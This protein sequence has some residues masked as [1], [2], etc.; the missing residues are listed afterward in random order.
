MQITII[1]FPGIVI[2][3]PVL[4]LR[5][6]KF[7][8][9]SKILISFFF[10]ISLPALCSGEEESGPNR[11]E[12]EGTF[13]QGIFTFLID[14]EVN[15][16]KLSRK[17]SLRKIS[18]ALPLKKESLPSSL[19]E[20]HKDLFWKFYVIY[21][22]VQNL[23]NMHPAKQAELT[24]RVYHDYKTI[25][26]DL[27]RALHSDAP[28]YYNHRKKTLYISSKNINE[29]ILAHELAHVVLCNYF[30]IEPPAQAQEILAIYCDSHLKDQTL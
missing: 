24:V 27:R 13:K 20:S 10:I 14:P 6:F 12:S 5:S 8:T 23:M 30:L 4:S 2:I 3:L 18:L 22:R 21:M 26:E 29:F 9:F 19:S 11:A 16:N 17:I 25:K 28:A 1:P 7:I 15:I